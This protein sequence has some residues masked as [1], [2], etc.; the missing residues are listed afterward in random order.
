MKKT[1]QENMKNIPFWKE[2]KEAQ[3]RA[4]KLGYELTKIDPAFAGIMEAMDTVDCLGFHFPE[5]NNIFEESTEP[6]V[7]KEVMYMQATDEFRDLVEQAY[8]VGFTAAIC[9]FT[10]QNILT[11][12]TKPGSNWLDTHFRYK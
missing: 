6:G 5:T 12:D 1:K 10:S 7:R 9:R 2:R 4:A 11:H 8:I 3:K